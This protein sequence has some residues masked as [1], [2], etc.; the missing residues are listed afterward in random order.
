[1]AVSKKAQEFISRK[2]K[3]NIREG[4]HRQQAIAVAHSQAREKGFKVPKPRM[5]S[6]IITAS[7]IRKKKKKR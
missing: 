2:I 1:M 6:E 4:M 7:Q 3:T 5:K